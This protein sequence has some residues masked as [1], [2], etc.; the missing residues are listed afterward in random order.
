MNLV[1]SQVEESIYQVDVTEDGQP[2]PPR[3]DK[4]NVEMLFV[5]GDGVILVSTSCIPSECTDSRSPHRRN[6]ILIVSCMC[7][8]CGVLSL[9]HKQTNPHAFVHCIKL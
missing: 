7:I 5:R 3:V 2:L 1:L 6:S 8:I 4:R 9:G